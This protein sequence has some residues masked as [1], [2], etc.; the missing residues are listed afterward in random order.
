MRQHVN[1]LSRFFQL[2]LKLPAPTALFENANSPIHLD[3]GS[4]RGKFLLE[5]A[6]AEPNWNY[7]GVEIRRPLVDAANYEK[8]LLELSNVHF[9]FCNAN[10]SL[11][12]WLSLLPKDLLHQVSIQFPD[13]WFK[14]RHKKRRVLQPKLLMS[15]SSALKPGG[16]LFIQSDLLDVVMPMV[17]LINKSGYFHHLIE[18]EAQGF[19]DYNPMPFSSER[20]RYVMNQ[21]LP[22]YRALFERNSVTLPHLSQLD[23]LT[24]QDSI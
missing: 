14:K 12:E 24:I 9:L 19:L 6:S 23:L 3:I 11:Q 2:P 8:E 16:K 13:P 17:E 7:L 1:P 5:M 20:E 22:I 21:G 15:L 10:V 18:S 4:A